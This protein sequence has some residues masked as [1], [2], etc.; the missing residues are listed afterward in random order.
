MGLLATQWDKLLI[1]N[2]KGNAEYIKS[3]KREGFDDI[4]KDIISEKHTSRVSFPQNLRSSNIYDPEQ[5][6]SFKEYNT[7]SMKTKFGKNRRV[8]IMKQ[9]LQ[10]Q[11]PGKTFENIKIIPSIMPHALDITPEI[12]IKNELYFIV[13]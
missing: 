13:V 1:H 5:F 7:N 8:S 12:K 11:A 10:T 4:N 2:W 3:L 9:R 6:L